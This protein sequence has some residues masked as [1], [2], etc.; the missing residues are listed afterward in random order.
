MPSPRLR[1]LRWLLLL[2]AIVLVALQLGCVRRRMTV[3]TNPPGAMVYI[4]DYPIGT[5]RVSAN[6]TYYGTRKLRLV[7]D[8]YE[9]LTV[10]EPLRAPWYQVPPLDF[11]S[12]NLV[13]AE[14]R[15]RRV[16]SY[17]LVPQRVVPPEELLGRA[18]RLRSR[19]QSSGMV[20]STSAPSPAPG[21][22]PFGPATGPSLAPGIPPGGG[23]GQPQLPP[24]GWQGT[25]P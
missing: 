24:D 21:A 22:Q 23:L 6:F 18:E 10:M 17:Q 8:G 9:T 14:I 7:K 16:L 12:E 20:R 25:G 3:R 2:V 4:D 11:V 5:T 15:D 13:P 19:A 1:R